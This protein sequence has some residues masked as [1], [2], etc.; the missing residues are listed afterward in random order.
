MELFDMIERGE[1]KEGQKLSSLVTEM[2]KF[3]YFCLCITIH[4]PTNRL[5]FVRGL[6][7]RDHNS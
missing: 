7:M 3:R 5:S 2:H 1:L 6:F 4:L